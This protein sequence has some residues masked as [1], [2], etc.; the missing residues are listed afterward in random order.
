MNVLIDAYLDRNVGDDLMVREVVKNFPSL[1]F[2]VKISDESRMLPFSDLKNICIHRGENI[3]KIIMVG[4]SMFEIGSTAEII[5]RYRTTVRRFKK[6]RKSGGKIAIVGVSISSVC[7]KLAW[8]VIKSQLKQTDIVTVRDS[9]SA[10]MF[11]MMKIQSS[12][13]SDMIFGCE[14]EKYEDKSGLA[15]SAYRNVRTPDKNLECCKKYAEIADEYINQTGKKV[16][17]L[18]FDCEDENDLS[19]AHTIFALMKNKLNAEIAAYTGDAKEIFDAIGKSECMIG[20][21]FHSIVI[22]AMLGVPVVCVSY[23]QKTDNMLSDFKFLGEVIDYRD[24]EN[25]ETS[26]LVSRIANK[27]DCFML[28]DE[29]IRE[30]KKSS[31]GHLK[32]LEEFL[33]S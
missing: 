8:W 13:Y 19:A 24:I 3:D 15:I 5:D 31:N 27:K 28:S 18:A 29:E 9:H 22:G 26:D 6:F 10:N 30:A 20:T 23:S 11:K 4:G 14:Y 2:F 32:A 21:R 25:I 12:F 16:R 33:N 17:L 7:R 1:N